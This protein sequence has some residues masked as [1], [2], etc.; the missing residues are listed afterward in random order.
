MIQL[1]ISILEKY[2]FENAKKKEAIT[3]EKYEVIYDMHSSNI[4]T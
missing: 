2:I 3:L 1:N 4:T